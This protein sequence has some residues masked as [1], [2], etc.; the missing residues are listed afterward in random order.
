MVDGGRQPAA[1]PSQ[2]ARMDVNIN[3]NPVSEEQENAE[4]DV[5]LA[6]SPR[7]YITLVPDS[8][9]SPS[10]QEN[11]RSRKAA[12]NPSSSADLELKHYG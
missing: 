10:I 4:I 3:P 1:A 9:E 8:T 5:H 7:H 12:L 6:E 11:P 2:T